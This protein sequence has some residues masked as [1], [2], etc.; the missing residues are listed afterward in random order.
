MKSITKNSYIKN[1]IKL[2]DYYGL[3]FFKIFVDL[4]KIYDLTNKQKYLI[5]I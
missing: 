1:F 4:K 2:K 3:F 5:L